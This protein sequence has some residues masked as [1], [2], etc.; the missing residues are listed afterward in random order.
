MARTAAFLAL[1]LVSG[2]DPVQVPFGKAPNLDGTIAGPE[3]EDATSIDVSEGVTAHVKQTESH[4]LMGVK[5]GAAGI[6]SVL[7]QRG[8]SVFVL[9]SSA[10]IDHAE[11]RFDKAKGDWK[12]ERKFDFGAWRTSKDD[13]KTRMAKFEK[14]K[15]WVAAFHSGR[16]PAEGAGSE[17]RISWALLGVDPK[18]APRRPL[19]L[20]IIDGSPWPA[21][22]KED[23]QVLFEKI[24]MGGLPE[25]MVFVPDAWAS[26]APKTAWAK[27]D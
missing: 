11:Y 21:G 27:K 18:Q 13:L 22:V 26:L 24:H 4:L 15:G 20:M 16:E 10:A 17:F 6:T 9:H 12:L 2:T 19:R 7:F 3:W 14:E 5:R 23:P 8:E 1:L 25:R